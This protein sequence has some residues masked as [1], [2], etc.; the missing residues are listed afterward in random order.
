ML[1]SAYGQL[2]TAAAAGA[3]SP[4]Y[5]F[6]AGEQG[7]WY[8]P[9][10]L[11]TLFQDS[12]GTTPVTAVGQPVGR[13]LDKSGRGNHASQTV[14]TS[15]PVLHQDSGGRY[16]LLFDGVDDGLQTPSINFSGTDKMTV[17][18]GARKLRDSAVS[19]L[20]E[21]SVDTNSNPGTFNLAAPTSTSTVGRD[22]FR[23]R[24]SVADFVDAGGVTAAPA[25][26]VYTGSADIAAPS[27]VFRTNGV[28]RAANST[29]Q[30]AGNYGSY[31][32]FIARR[33]GSSL[34]YNGRLYSLIVRGAATTQSQIEQAERW[35]NGK[36]GAY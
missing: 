14:A 19:I 34:T 7:A 28:E 30:G 17:F 21:L 11:S 22:A 6:A 35:V 24:G 23:S 16:Y 9:G 5:L 26:V 2:F 32:L 18:A 27:I 29:S 15:R 1:G 20:I 3:W 8:D 12:A 25:T 36:T 31:P 33:G 4:A 13:I 10:D